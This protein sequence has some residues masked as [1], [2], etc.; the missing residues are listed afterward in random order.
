[1]ELLPHPHL[2]TEP[3]PDPT[4]GGPPVADGTVIDCD[5]CVARDTPACTDCV[6]TFLCS[7]APDEAVVIVVAEARALRLLG[8]AGLV[9]RLRHRRRTG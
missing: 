2:A 7:R 8:D 5:V 9:P 4:P 3:G 1:M 6:V